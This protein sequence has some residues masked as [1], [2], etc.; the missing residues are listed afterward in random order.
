MTLIPVRWLLLALVLLWG[1][2]SRGQEIQ[3]EPV[4][5]LPELPL[6]TQPSATPELQSM[7]LVWELVPENDSESNN[8]KSINIAWEAIKPS[9]SLQSSGSLDAPSSAHAD[10]KSLIWVAVDENEIIKAVKEDITPEMN[11]IEEAH[12]VAYQV[13][14]A[15]ASTFANHRALWR[16]ERWHPQITG[17][18]P[19]GFGPQG[20]MASIGISGI[21]C[22]ANGVCTQPNSWE[23]YLDQIEESGEAQLEGSIGFG[24]AEKLLGI[25]LTTYVEETKLPLGDRN[26]QG[27]AADANLFDEYYIGVHLSRNIGL[28]TAFRVGIN[29]WIDVKKCGDSCGFPKSAY[30]V[31][32]QRIRIKDDQTSWFPN[33]YITLGAGNGEFRSLSEKFRASVNAQKKA[34]CST[35]GYLPDEPCGINTRSRAVLSAANY[36]QLAPIGSAAL[37]VVSGLNLIGEWSQGNLNAGI[38]VRPFKEIGLVFTG[39][40]NTLLPTCDYGC[41]LTINNV[42]A[43]I[44]DNLTTERAKFSFTASLD[45]KF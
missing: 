8:N 3:W 11:S 1:G 43:R 5:P 26:T 44:E 16:N 30:G 9:V 12:N 31:I 14:E 22:T 33:A 29:N 4:P 15:T 35:F 36:G 23:D 10:A 42:P 45:I 17:S 27:S 21:D 28:D 41:T 25:T 38:S 39:M 24:D 40:W 6:P 37:E 13:L 7:Q 19:L 34:D 18:I 20:L 32:S 2:A